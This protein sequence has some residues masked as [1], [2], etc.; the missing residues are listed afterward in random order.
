VEFRDDWL[1]E[2]NVALGTADPGVMPD[3]S[4]DPM[5]PG[6]VLVEPEKQEILED[7]LATNL[8]VKVTRIYEKIPDLD[9]ETEAAAAAGFGYK[10]EYPFG[11]TDYP[12]VTWRYPAS[13]IVAGTPLSDTC[14][15]AGYTDLVLIG[16]EYEKANGRI[17]AVNKVYADANGPIII[18]SEYDERIQQPVMTTKQ[19]IAEASMPQTAA[20]M[21]DEI[22]GYTS[23]GTAI[24]SIASG[25]VTT[26]TAHGLTAGKEVYFPSLVG[27]SGDIIEGD[28]SGIGEYF[29]IASG[30]TTTQFR[31]STTKGGSSATGSATSGSAPKVRNLERG[32][33]R[34]YKSLN[35]DKLRTIQITAKVDIDGLDVLRNGTAKTYYAQHRFSFP[36]ELTSAEYYWAEA[37]DG[38]GDDWAFDVALE[39]VI[40]QGYTGPCAALITEFYTSN[41]GRIAAPAITSFRP[42]AVSI[43][44]AFVFYGPSRASAAARTFTIP[45]TLHAAITIGNSSSVAP[46]ATDGSIYTSIPATSPTAAT[47]LGAITVAYEPSKFRFGLTFYQKIQIYNPNG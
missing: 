24:T 45:P 10:V 25:L 41:P 23:A 22:N 12:Q 30:L 18:E 19:I 38:S 15:V 29:V 5:F 6:A 21:N 39:A 20:A 46:N 28:T 27:E 35:W 47:G 7:P 1:T 32:T 11:V 33:I 16:Q 26:S 17:I 9:D 14:P 34:E 43:P 31:V 8:Y 3:D 42:V 44:Y 4:G 36:D 40:K 13:A 2:A 37:W